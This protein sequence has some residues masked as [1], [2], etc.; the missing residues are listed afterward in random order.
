MKLFSSLIVCL[1]SFQTISTMQV[2]DLRFLAGTWK[3]EN[4]ESYETWTIKN[5]NALEGSSYKVKNGIKV[6]GELLSIKINGDKI[7]Y[8]AKVLNQ[9]NGQTI[10]FVLNRAVKDKLSFENLAHDFPKKIQYVK[11]NDSTLFVSVLGEN[12][13]GFSYN[14]IKQSST[15]L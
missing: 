2:K 3:I 6:V 10:E 1:V 5:D 13:K 15:S 11:K 4:K 8:A 12:D 9:N 7:S 14:L